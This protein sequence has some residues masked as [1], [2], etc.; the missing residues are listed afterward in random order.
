ME[1]AGCGVRHQLLSNVRTVY[2]SGANL[3]VFTMV[4]MDVRERAMRMPISVAKYFVW[5]VCFVF[6]ER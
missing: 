1:L 5:G 3:R 2:L 6:C 4:L